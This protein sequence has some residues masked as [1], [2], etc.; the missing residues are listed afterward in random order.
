MSCG[1]AHAPSAAAGAESPAFTSERYQ[2]FEVA[3]LT[4]SPQESMGQDPTSQIRIKL[5]DHEI[6]QA[7][8][9]QPSRAKVLR[10]SWK[11]QVR[12]LIDEKKALHSHFQ[13]RK[14]GLIMNV[15][16][17]LA[18]EFNEHFIRSISNLLDNGP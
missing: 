3:G 7:A 9:P 5:F 15:G 4:L 1:L 6:R 16:D 18:F 10:Q 13:G 12:N 2:V 11:D 14:I 8:R 17:K